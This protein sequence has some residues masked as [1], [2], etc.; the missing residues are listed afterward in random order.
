MPDI[1]N[2]QQLAVALELN[3]QELLECHVYQKEEEKVGTEKVLQEALAY[4]QMRIG[5]ARRKCEF[6]LILAWGLM[7]ALIYVMC[8]Y[9]NLNQHLE[10]RAL[11]I[12]FLVLE[13][14]LMGNVLRVLWE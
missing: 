11:L 10:L 9:M 3:L 1:D 12:G 4:A 6:I 5:K 13:V 2:M 8:T 7:F 14:G